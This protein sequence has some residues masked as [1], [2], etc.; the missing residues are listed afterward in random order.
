METL[1]QSLPVRLEKARWRGL[2][3]L[4]KTKLLTRALTFTPPPGSFLTSQSSLFSHL[5]PHHSPNFMADSNS[6]S[7][8]LL[9]LITAMHRGQ[10]R[11]SLHPAEPRLSNLSAREQQPEPPTPGS[12]AGQLLELR[13]DYGMPLSSIAEEL[14]KHTGCHVT[15]TTIHRWMN[16][17]NMGRKVSPGALQEALQKIRRNHEPHEEGAWADPTEVATTIQEWRQHSS[18][19]QL[20][21]AA[22]VPAPTLRAWYRGAH[23]V[24]RGRWV[25]VVR[26]VNQALSPS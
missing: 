5:F 17:G 26:R 9:R 10:A 22:G 14:A 19:A 1:F 8:R 11:L 6:S 12:L 7:K 15:P 4:Q 21:S 23:S 16:N 24:P 3:R 2:R 18:M 20:A 13:R 25:E